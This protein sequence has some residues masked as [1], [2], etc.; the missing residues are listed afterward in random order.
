MEEDRQYGYGGPGSGPEPEP[1]E[2][3]FLT[4]EDGQT[5]NRRVQPEENWQ[6]DD[7]QKEDLQGQYRKVEYRGYTEPKRQ[8][9]MA[10]ASLVMGILGIVTACCCYGGLIFGCLGI[11][12]SL[13]SKMGDTMEGYAKAGLITSI[14]ALVLAPLSL[15]F[16]W[17]TM[18]SLMAGGV[19]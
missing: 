5:V 9:N 14:V 18:L 3:V 11:L 7:W 4:E 16:L 2:E 10:L 17:G 6:K 13:L 19:Y 8:S 15:I 1:P 12:F